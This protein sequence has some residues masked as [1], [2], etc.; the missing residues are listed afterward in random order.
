MLFKNVI[1]SAVWRTDVRRAREERGRPDQR[2]AE[3]TRP[4]RMSPWIKMVLVEVVRLK[5][6]FENKAH[7][8]YRL[9][10]GY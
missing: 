9:D 8:I 6:S 2:P 5:I 3:S 7:R 10:L 4:E 1:L